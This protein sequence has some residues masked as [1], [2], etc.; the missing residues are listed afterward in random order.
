MKRGSTP[1]LKRATEGEARRVVH[2][3]AGQRVLW[4]PWV[5]EHQGSEV[6]R[7][8]CRAS[9]TRAQWFAKVGTAQLPDC[10]RVA[11]WTAAV[12]ELTKVALDDAATES[13]NALQLR[14]LE[15]CKA[16]G[17]EWGV[18]WEKFGDRYDYAVDRSQTLARKLARATIGTG[19]IEK[20][21]MKTILDRFSHHLMI[22]L[23]IAEVLGDDVEHFDRTCVELYLE[24]FFPCGYRGKYPKGKIVVY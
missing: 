22:T 10:V 6:C 21:L 7:R 18:E 15:A 17:P 13:L 5:A 23:A 16:R 19:P 8:S 4:V 2:S 1:S 20:K 14:A 11:D 12:S 9:Q 3:L 24:G